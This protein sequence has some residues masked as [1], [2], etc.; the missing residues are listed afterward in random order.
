MTRFGNILLILWAAFFCRNV[1]AQEKQPVFAS[2]CL[3][4]IYAGLPPECRQAVGRQSTCYLPAAKRQMY[5]HRNGRGEITGMG[6]QLFPEA[7]AGAFS[8]ELLDFLERTALELLLQPNNQRVAAKLKEYKMSWTYNGNAL[9]EGLFRNFADCLVAITDS[10]AFNLQHDSLVYKAQWSHPVRGHINVTFPAQYS[11]IAGKDSKELGDELSEILLSFKRDET[12]KPAPAEDTDDTG[13]FSR[14]HD[15]M[16]YVK[17]GKPFII[18]DINSD[19]YYRKNGERTYKP[20]YNKSYQYETLA[21]LFVLDGMPGTS[22]VL[23]ITHRKYGYTEQKYH[24]RLADF[25]AFFSRNFETYVGFE[26]ATLPGIKAVVILY[27]RKF[28]YVNMLM[29]DTFEN[30]FFGN[31]NHIPCRMYAFIPSHNIRSLFG[32]SDLKSKD[33]NEYE[34]ILFE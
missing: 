19:T 30:A 26:P 25:I 29:V 17:R 34:Q 6:L 9:G 21:N 23:D 3:E 7:Y 28:N 4:R 22:P 33:I 18:P 11:V 32:G 31:D 1:Y 8:Q 20:L 27:N 14:Y 5:V 24:I 15:D 2:L 13:E 12:A 16:I 10:T